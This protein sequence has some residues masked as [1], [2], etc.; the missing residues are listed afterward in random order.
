MECSYYDGWSV[1]TLSDAKIDTYEWKLARACG[2]GENSSDNYVKN[3]T[4]ELKADSTF[5]LHK[6][7]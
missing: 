6:A 1:N 3:C 2:F 5:V 7:Y 4:L